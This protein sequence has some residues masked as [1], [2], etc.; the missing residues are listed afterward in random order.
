VLLIELDSADVAS[1][2]RIGQQQLGAPLTCP[3]LDCLEQETADA[4]TS[5]P[6]LDRQVV[7]MHPTA[8]GVQARLNRCVRHGLVKLRLR[9]RNGHAVELGGKP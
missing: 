2:V 6:S 3:V 4:A 5:V 7:E 8:T 1:Q 9:V